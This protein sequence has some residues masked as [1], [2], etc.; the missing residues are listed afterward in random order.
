MSREEAAILGFQENTGFLNVRATCGEASDSVLSL[1]LRGTRALV[2]AGFSRLFA[3]LLRVTEWI[4]A[5]GSHVPLPL[6]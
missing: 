3:P 4:V 2:L 5:R 6:S 1:A